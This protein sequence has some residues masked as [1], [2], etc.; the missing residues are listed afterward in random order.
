MSWVEA[1]ERLQEEGIIHRVN[2]SQGFVLWNTNL[3]LGWLDWCV[4]YSRLEDCYSLY[5]P[6]ELCMTANRAENRDLTA[7]YA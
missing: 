1:I 3:N 5:F 4:A 2:K 7:Q 6:S